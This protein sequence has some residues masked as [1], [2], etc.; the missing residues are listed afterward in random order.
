[1]I[2]GGSICS[3]EGSKVRAGFSDSNSNCHP[4]RSEGPAVCLREKLQ[5][6]RFAQD[7]NL[8]TM[9]SGSFYFSRKISGAKCAKLSRHTIQVC[10][11]GVSMA[12]TGTSL[13]LSQA[14]NLR[15]GVTRSSSVPQAIQSRCRLTVFPF[16]AASSSFSRCPIAELNPPTQPNCSG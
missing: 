5:V 11:P 1:M 15:F 12:V 6:L 10:K 2:S 3:I 4:E 14:M 7:D 16:S 13:V 8:G 9:N